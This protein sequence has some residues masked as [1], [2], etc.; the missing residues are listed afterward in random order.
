MSIQSS[1]GNAKTLWLIAMPAMWACAAWGQSFTGSLL[2]TVTDTSGAVAANVTVTA[3][4]SET[5]DKRNGATNAAGQYNLTAIPPGRYRLDV[6]R[7]GFKHWQRADVQVEVLQGV[8]IDIVLEPGSISETIK[9]TAESPLLETDNAALGAVVDNK[10]IVDLPLNGRNPMAL[11]ELTPGV[12]PGAQ[13]QFGGQPV[14]QNVYAQGTFTVNSGIQSQSESLVDGVPNN[15]FLWNS[16]A[17]IARVIQI[18]SK[19]YS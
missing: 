8:R 3:T 16:P 10:K 1:K 4:N 2:G 11:V 15:A 14:L 12:V 19:L 9:V 7:N 17:F 5:G 13:N 18:A 6:E